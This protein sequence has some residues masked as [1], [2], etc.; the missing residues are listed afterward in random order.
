MRLS[1][2]AAPTAKQWLGALIT[3]FLLLV[4]GNGGVVLA[5]QH[6]ATGLVSLLVAMIPV[7]VAIIEH[8]GKGM[9]NAKTILGLLLG[10]GGIIALVGPDS[11]FGHSSSSSLF[12]IAA[13]AIGSLGWSIGSIYTRKAELPK[14][15]FLAT[16]MQMLCGGVLMS[17]VS[18]GLGEFEHA[19][20]LAVS[21]ASIGGLFYL[22]IFGSIIGF[23]SFTWLLTH[24]PAGKIATYAYVNPIVAVF[25]GWAMLGEKVTMQTAYAGALILAAVWLIT[26]AKKPAAVLPSP[27][28]AVEREQISV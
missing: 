6:T 4:M 25:L 17:A 16:A 27:R 15:P 11:L 26:S 7:Y 19:N 9:P 5:E 21:P 13:C 2:T 22:I 20:I 10:T 8:I 1:G 12:G 18:F 23:S 3:G 14:S 28:L 24:I